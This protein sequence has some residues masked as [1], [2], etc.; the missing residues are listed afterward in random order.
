MELQAASTDKA[1]I[2]NIV[3]Y[4]FIMIFI[5]NGKLVN[6]SLITPIG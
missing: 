2:A 5:E 6:I 4:L 1:M 3:V